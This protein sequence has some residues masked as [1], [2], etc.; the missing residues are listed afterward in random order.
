M[1]EGTRT[2]WYLIAADQRVE[3][4]PFA[5]EGDA[6]RAAGWLDDHGM[7]AHPAPWRPHFSRAGLSIGNRWRP[8]RQ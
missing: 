4:G 7:G 8:R 6:V 2:G 3:A 5:T 1:L